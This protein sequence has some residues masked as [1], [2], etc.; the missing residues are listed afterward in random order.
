MGRWLEP[1]GRAAFTLAGLTLAGIGAVLAFA[2]PGWSIGPLVGDDAGYYFAI[3]RNFCLGYGL[4]FDRLHPTNG[5]NPLYPLVLI[6][7][8]K[9]LPGSLPLV[10]CYRVGV[11][12]GFAAVVLSLLPY[13]RVV[14]A[15][16]S[17]GEFSRESRILLRGAG[18]AFFALFIATK[19]HYGMDPPLVLLIGLW[20]LARV[21]RRGLLAAG[22]KEA[23]LD[24][25]LLGL[26]F[27]ARVDSLP[28]LAAAWALMGLETIAH[29]STWRPFLGRLAVTAAVCSP[30]LIGSTARFGTWLPVSA[31]I[32]SS[33]PQLDLERSLAT[34]RG[35]SLGPADV[36]TFLAAYLLAWGTIA[37]LAPRIACA[38]RA[39]TPLE[40]WSAALGLMALYLVGR[41]SYMLLFS[42]ADVQGGYIVLAHVF[43]VMAFFAALG[44]LTARWRARGPAVERGL[45]VL[46]GTALVL[47]ATAAFAGKLQLTLAR[48]EGRAASG[49]PD[50]AQLGRD[51]HAHTGPHDV[52][53]GGS[54]GLTGFFSDRP[55]INGDGVVNTYDYQRV[56]AAPGT[57]GEG[58]LQ[59]YMRAN[60]VTH[61]AFVLSRGE[62]PE[63]A[64]TIRLGEYSWLY[65]RANHYEVSA[66][67]IVLERPSARG[68]PGSG[69]F[70]LAR[71]SP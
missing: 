14:D 13:L 24:G 5:F 54:F 37:V 21:C 53:F 39:R 49:A 71:W 56:F 23:A 70:Y 29:R 64:A 66:R 62:Q 57:H 16:L 26:L 30:Y 63:G 41:L 48:R 28:F 65:G 4:S 59:D 8:D 50:E 35:T 18:A 19:R 47:V 11:L 25:C 69:M 38:V 22:A 52:I 12:A 3:A 10:A 31:R 17:R 43:I 36:W 9:L 1:A 45:A 33:F 6:P 46:A 61:V 15:S 67:D 42:R 27:L 58:G 32:K 40:P 20:Y 44:P 51:V 2:P 55:W 68:R 60:R 34:I 7:L